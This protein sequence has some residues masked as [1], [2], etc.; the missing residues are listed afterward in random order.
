MKSVFVIFHEYETTSG[1]DSVK[2][3]GIYSSE[4]TGK[5]FTHGP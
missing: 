4:E 3:R 1:C 5:A 2:L